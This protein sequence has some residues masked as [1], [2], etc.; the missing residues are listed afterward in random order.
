MSPV[1]CSEHREQPALYR[2]EGCRRRLC[3]ECV[4]HGH[5]LLFCRH[6]RERAVPFTEGAP[7]TTPEIA[8]AARHARP[9]RLADAFAYA[10]RGR[11][12]LT[13]PAYV[14]FM[15]F[16]G[17]LPTLFALIPLLL[18]L[19]LVPGFLFAVV[20]ST[21]DAD[22]ELPEWPDYGD[23]VA[24]LA[25]WRDA[26]GIGLGAALPWLLFRRL[27]GCDVES[28]LVE[29]P[30]LCQLATVVGTTAGF[31]IALFGLGAVG[32]FQSGWLSF[33][34]D[35]HLR[36]LATGTG[37]EAPRF[38]LLVALLLA[39]ATIA[40]RLL[41]GIPLRGAAIVHAV[42]AYA[43]LTSAHLA[44]LLFRRHRQRLEAIYLD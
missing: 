15:M 40:V 29:D 39:A 32:A 21:W 20:R 34:I 18:V 31:V 14:A 13:I 23:F 27:A 5:R 4:E 43:G 16:V 33:R 26:A 37:G 22:D 19:I 41:A 24:R 28:W 3:E 42:I 10:W 25:E 36:A 12:A 11:G 2:C 1:P 7:S 6:C 38:A 30:S 9:Y 35:L 44:G 8:R 17:L